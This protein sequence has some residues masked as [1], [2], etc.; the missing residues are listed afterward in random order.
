MFTEKNTIELYEARPRDAQLEVENERK[1]LRLAE[2][3]QKLLEH[4]LF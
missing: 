2:Q 4:D 3:Q 1:K